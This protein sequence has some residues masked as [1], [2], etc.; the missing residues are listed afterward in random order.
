MSPGSRPSSLTAHNVFHHEMMTRT[1]TKNLGKRPRV[2]DQKVDMIPERAVAREGIRYPI[3]TKAEEPLAQMLSSGYRAQSKGDLFGLSL[4]TLACSSF[5]NQTYASLCGT[6][7]GSTI[8]FYT[9]GG[10]RYNNIGS[11]LQYNSK[12]QVFGTDD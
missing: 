3:N 4:K 1:V 8:N 9:G 12:H 2:T 7:S 10:S 6:C 11:G 5:P